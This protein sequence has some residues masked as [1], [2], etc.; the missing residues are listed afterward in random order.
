MVKFASSTLLLLTLLLNS[1]GRNNPVRV[2][3]FIRDTLTSEPLIGANVLFN[4][5]IETV[6]NHN[7]YFCGNV[8]NVGFLQIELSFIGYQKRIL[9]INVVKDT[10]LNIDLIPGIGLTEVKISGSLVKKRDVG[11]LEIPIEQIIKMPSLSGEPDILKAFQMMPG[12]QMGSE[13][14]SGIYVRGGTP[15]QNLY[16]IDN[17]PLYNVSHMGGFMSAFDASSVKK[18][19]L[20][21]GYIPARYGGKIASV[22]DVRL[23]DGNTNA[24]KQELMFGVLASRYFTEG[25]LNDKT[26]YVAS[27]RRCNIDLPMRLFSKLRA[28]GTMEAYTF[29]DF[30]AKIVRNIN[31]KNKLSGIIYYGRDV[32]ISKEK[33]KGSY[34][35][36][37]EARELNSL[38]R[39]RWGNLV[40]AINWLHVFNNSTTADFSAGQSWYFSRVKEKT[41]VTSSEENYD[42]SSI[43]YSGISD[44]FIKG[45]FNFNTNKYQF[46]AGLGIVAHTFV[47]SE[48]SCNLSGNNGDGDLDIDIHDR[49]D[50][51]ALE[52]SNYYDLTF[53]LGDKV[54]VLSGVF[55]MYW[56]SVSSV[57]AEPRIAVHYRPVNNLM[58]RGICTRTSQYV[59]LLT[60]NGSR[61]I[62]DLWIPSTNKINP[63]HANQLNLGLTYNLNGIEF[64]IDGWLKKMENLI[65]FKPGYSL[66]NMNPFESAVEIQGR[67]VAKGV[68]FM[69]QKK[70]GRNTG[71]IAYSWSKNDRKFE[72]INFGETFPFKHDR[73][74]EFKLVYMLAISERIDFSLAWIY[75]S[76]NPMTLS[77]KQYPA[78]DLVKNG[79]TTDVMPI[80]HFYSGVNNFRME[81]YHRLDIGI[82]FHKQLKKGLRTFSLGLYNAYNRQ[83]AYNYFYKRQ[84]SGE[85][86]FKK[87]IYFPIIPNV[88]YTLKF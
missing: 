5:S 35:Y 2:C 6:T 8:S 7:G 43:I 18:V 70:R 3:G 77:T 44:F 14:T 87:R 49:E 13:G 72:N 38:Y 62:P 81:D 63:Q 10:L 82:D 1:Y 12:V 15:D 26:T 46:S 41:K 45:D 79:N 37:D 83:N 68:E 11:S 53:S 16:L 69:A 75:T 71:W 78:I 48:I 57:S 74:H 66:F 59:H 31:L 4:G 42:E 58:L 9:N 30:N 17:I 84:A 54:S 64:S 73:P 34:I 47:P 50:V 55:F 22:L 61:L 80:A 29:M 21:K 88:S 67:G 52:L 24:R 27:I 33:T 20:Y 56:P 23:K 39:N 65:T 25:P 36:V 40:S 85:I 19:N 76:G 28:D 32:I 51:F 86:V 60:S